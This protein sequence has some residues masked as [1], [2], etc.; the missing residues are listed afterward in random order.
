V[1]FPWL[2]VLVAVPAVG[3]IVVALL[4]K[5]PQTAD[6]LAKQVAIAI[7]VI[8]FIV[9]V[10]AAAQFR[11][12]GP[13]FQLTETYV[14]IEPFG[15]HWAVGVSGI[16]LALVLLATFITPLVLLAMWNEAE[17]SGRSVKAFFALLLLMEAMVLGT[18][19]A[20]D[21]LL[22]YILFEAMLIPMYFLIGL[23]GGPKRT[24]AAV[25]FLLYNLFGGLIM[26]AAVIGLYVQSARAGDG[27]FLLS[28]LTGLDISS[29]TQG[30]LFVG[31]MLAFAIK[32]PMWPFHTWLPD[33]AAEAT[34]SNAAY[35]SGVVDKVGTFGM[36]HLVLPLF[37]DASHTFAPYVVTLALISMVYGALLAIGQTDLKR[38]IAYTSISHFG[39]IVLGIFAFTT[40]GQTGSTLYMVNHGFSTVA[41][42]VIIGFL[43]VRRGSRN[44]W[45]YG[46]VQRPAPVLA[47]VFLVAGLSG[48]GLPGLSTFVSEFLVLLGTFS[49]Y[50]IAGIIATA[51][52][53]LAAI[54]ILLMYK[55][56]MNGPVRPAVEGFPEIRGRELAVVAPML[57]VIVALG[58]YPKPLIDV[59]NHGV[60]PTM[61]Q[62]DETDPEPLVPVAE[63]TAE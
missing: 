1:T 31:F 57:A 48:L 8:A 28:E 54:Y 59:I 11:T 36:I 41:L 23:Y 5:N 53:I 27:T 43:I 12:D 38:L 52:I 34:P 56:T 55:R 16:G 3:A 39:L 62:V 45:D 24:Y 58:V 2:S 42:F 35:L 26:L 46:G 25:K 29:T 32:A 17:E 15:V 13:Q 6:R 60:E 9:S 10:I 44:L 20:T 22:F 4:P 33:T 49:R 47:G 37:P 30:W 63:G 61:E 19:V 40:Q 51:S 18:F 7:S 50:R 14:W 21:V